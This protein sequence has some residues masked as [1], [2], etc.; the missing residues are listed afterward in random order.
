MG[1]NWQ[2]GLVQSCARA[3]SQLGHEVKLL[4]PPGREWFRKRLIPPKITNVKKIETWLMKWFRNDFNH[5]VL[6]KAL[7]FKPDSYFV[8]NES[9]IYPETIS[10]I[11]KRTICKFICWLGDNPFD[12][13]RYSCLPVN[14]DLF[15]FIFVGEPL[16]IPNIKMITN[17]GVVEYLPGAADPEI[18]RPVDID[19]QTREYFY[20]PL[21]YVSN[22][23]GAKA[24]GLYRGALLNSVVGH[25]L[26]LWGDIGWE[27]YYQFFPELKRAYQ[28]KETSLEETNIINQI[29]N[30]T[31]AFS[32]PQV[33]TAPV[34]RIFEI[35]AS[36]GFQIADYR[37]EIDK[38]FPKGL[39][40][41]FSSKE[42][43][44]KKIE[45]FLSHP[46]E[47]RDLARK[48]RSLVLK[49]HTFKQRAEE[50]MSYLPD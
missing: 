16:W 19:I 26:K 28:G 24:E 15:D 3:L 47:A 41:Q 20:A 8:F 25:G 9:Y 44:S 29:S 4:L 2:G 14:L 27:R 50:I 17:A 39:I 6:Q 38:L 32:N 33:F 31:L 35:P 46:E 42:E 48:T 5:M 34:L 30:I 45:Y 18:F 13:S 40:Q 49:K 1:Y 11:K 12:S 21:S 36:G 22:S 43:L 7:T 10:K 23:Y 37:S